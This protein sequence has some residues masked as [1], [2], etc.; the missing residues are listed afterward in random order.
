MSLESN[1]AQNWKDFKRQF[2]ILLQAREAANKADAVKIAMLLNCIGEKVT[3]RF[4]QLKWAL[5]GEDGLP[6]A[7]ED[8]NIYNDVVKKLEKHFKGKKRLVYHKYQFWSYHRPEGMAFL[9]Y[10]TNLQKLANVCEFQEKDNM[11]QDKIIFSTTDRELKKKLLEADDLTLEKA[12]EKCLAA[13]ITCKDIKEITG[14]T[15]AVDTVN[16]QR[17][18]QKKPRSS[19]A[20]KNT[21]KTSS[22]SQQESCGNCG[23]KHPPK[24]CP[25][26]GRECLICNKKNH[27]A[28][29]CRSKKKTTAAVTCNQ[30]D[31]EEP[32]VFEFSAI[33]QIDC[34]SQSEN[35]WWEKLLIE[36]SSKMTFKVDTGAQANLIPSEQWEKLPNKPIIRKSNARLQ[37]ITGSE[38]QHIGKATVTMM[39]KT[40]KVKAGVFITKNSNCAILG[41]QTAREL[42]LIGGSSAKVDAINSTY[43]GLTL[44]EVKKKYNSV[45]DD[46]QLGKY[47]GKY[48]IKLAEDAQPEINPPGRMPHKLMKPLRETLDEMQEKGVIEPVEHPTDWVNSMV[49]TEKKNGKLRPS[50]DP[51]E[52]NKYITREHY[53]IPTFQEVITRFGRPKY[54][55]IIDQS[56]AF[57]QVELDDDSKDLTTFQTPFGRYRFNGMPFGISSAS[58]VMQRKGYQMFG[59]IPGVHIIADDMLIAGNTEGEHDTA[60]TKVL[61]RAAE[62]NIKFSLPKLQ[63]QKP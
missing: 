28:K 20:E 25:A 3:E 39:R 19:D 61:E 23:K 56:W 32:D 36:D 13:E 29:M 57:W 22:T 59:D 52:L 63:F 51:R 49:C 10:F 16:R 4:D 9:D 27:F 44:E 26:Y 18:S 53:M 33:L 35:I 58:E 41:L 54:F 62:N 1:M 47:P 60:V 50:L 17:R 7:G 31:Q 21:D 30:S 42:G 11:I 48:R 12:K 43:R 55:T 37:S 24:Q 34:T 5:P 8:P 38:L 14:S 46:S 40:K 2:D 15:K 6:P 45:F